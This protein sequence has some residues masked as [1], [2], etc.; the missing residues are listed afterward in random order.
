MRFLQRNRINRVFVYFSLPHPLCNRETETE[1]E[2]QKDR[3][4]E[5][6]ELAHT[7]VE[8]GKSKSAG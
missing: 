6:K 5:I 7:I 1:K 8:A 3:E 4:R 2:R